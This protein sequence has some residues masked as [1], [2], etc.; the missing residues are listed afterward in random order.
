MNVTVECS[1]ELPKMAGS[2]AGHDGSG[3]DPALL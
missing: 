3:G 1:A 2:A